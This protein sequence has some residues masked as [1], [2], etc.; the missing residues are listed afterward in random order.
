MVHDVPVAEHFLRLILNTLNDCAVH[1]M[2]IVA[3]GSGKDAACNEQN[4]SDT[5][6]PV[7]HYDSL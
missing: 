2:E 6:D 5:T 4:S 3:F 1:E 7:S